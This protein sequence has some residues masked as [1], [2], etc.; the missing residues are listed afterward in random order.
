MNAGWS[1]FRPFRCEAVRM[2]SE[3]LQALLA[4]VERV[5]ADEDFMRRVGVLL[6]R[7]RELLDRLAEGSPGDRT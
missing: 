6:A 7:D 2:D 1:C 4:D 3:R 5:R